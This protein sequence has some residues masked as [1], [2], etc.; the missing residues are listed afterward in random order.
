MNIIITGASRGIGFACV[1]KMLEA[2]THKVIA[3]ARNIKP[4]QQFLNENPQFSEQLFIHE[5][6]IS[7]FENVA[8]L[9]KIEMSFSHIDILINNAG[10]LINKPFMELTKDDWQD[11]FDVNIFGCA[12]L[13][14]TVYPLLKKSNKAHIV[15]IG[16]MGGHEGTLKFS[17]LSA[18]SSSK[19]ALANLTE[20]LAEEWKTEGISVNCL[21]L[22]AVNTEMLGE[23]FPGYQA[24]LNAV[25]MADFIC[26]FSLKGNTF[27]NGKLLP[28]SLSTP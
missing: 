7:N 4:L 3:L 1:K 9:Q 15:N 10:L 14:Q 17:G 13:I 26:D 2:K 27:F 28:V 8:Y 21:M 11:I 12:K 25:E 19:A 23:A 22:G 16:S 18:Y 5:F 6:D 24:P 20:C